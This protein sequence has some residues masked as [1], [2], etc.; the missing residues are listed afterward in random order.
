MQ[1]LNEN[2][3]V[4]EKKVKNQEINFTEFDRGMQKF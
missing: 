2:F 1:F 3:V 4:I